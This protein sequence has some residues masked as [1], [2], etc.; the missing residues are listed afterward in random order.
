MNGGAKKKITNWARKAW[1]STP[2]EQ[3]TDFRDFAHFTKRI[4][5][6]WKNNPWFKLFINDTINQ[7]LI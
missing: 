7:G 3:R 6:E 2:P 5:R 1:D 4:K